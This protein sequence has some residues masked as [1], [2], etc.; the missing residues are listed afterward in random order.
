[1]RIP[2]EVETVSE[3]DVLGSVLLLQEGALSGEHALYEENKELEESKVAETSVACRGAQR[4]GGGE[5][6]TQTKVRDL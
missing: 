1:M 5:T 3:E 6:D 4:A 2:F